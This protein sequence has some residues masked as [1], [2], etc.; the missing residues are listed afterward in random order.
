MPRI[1]FG[2]T[3][4]LEYVSESPIPAPLPA[5]I[6]KRDAVLTILGAEQRGLDGI[7]VTG[8]LEAAS[9]DVVRPVAIY[10]VTDTKAPDTTLDPADYLKFS[11]PVVTYL[12]TDDAVDFEILASPPVHPG[13]NQPIPVTL[14]TLLEFAD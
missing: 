12:P 14:V 9:D 4:S 11:A 5:P 6:V 8:S 1:V 3:V 2:P 13:G 7:A 10:I